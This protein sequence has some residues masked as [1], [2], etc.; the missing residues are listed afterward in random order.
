MHS[1][2][3]DNF[4]LS[5]NPETGYTG[6]WRPE[7]LLSDFIG[8]EANG[9]WT[10]DIQDTELAD[11]GA[12]NGWS[13][14][15]TLGELFTTTGIDGTYTFQNVPTGEYT[16]R[17]QQ[18]TGWTQV[19]P[20]VPAIPGAVWANGEWT[21]TISDDP[22]D[23]DEL[24]NIVNVNFGNRAG[25]SGDYNDNGHV[26]AADYILWRRTL[27]T[28]VSPPGSGADGNG[29]G[30]VDAGDLTV[31]RANFGASA[32]GGG[33]ALAGGGGAS[34]GQGAAAMV[35]NETADGT[36]S[37]TA[38][39]GASSKSASGESVAAKWFIA[40]IDSSAAGSFAADISLGPAADMSNS[41]ETSDAALVA[42]LA[43][44][45]EVEEASGD[46]DAVN[47]EPDEWEDDSLEPIDSVFEVLG[48][49]I[50]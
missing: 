20:A 33:G 12:L 49:A 26:D 34:E 46:G 43:A 32:M 23:P 1:I 8:E 39:S 25:L 24:R 30:S 37:A 5:Y 7:G 17:E 28:P 48:S 35:V 9:I 6:T 42:W 31:W 29:S 13:I 21:V 40:P 16:I 15:I 22:T 50:G 19:A 27:A 18:Q 10:L 4:I 11:Q 2:G 3:S 44:M 38:G 14:E 41:S 36:V 47:V 45:A